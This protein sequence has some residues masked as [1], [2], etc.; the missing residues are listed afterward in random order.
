VRR[1]GVAAE[2][3]RLTHDVICGRPRAHLPH[4]FVV[5]CPCRGMN[6]NYQARVERSRRLA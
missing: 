4:D 1:L 5:P 2:V 3:L 6:A